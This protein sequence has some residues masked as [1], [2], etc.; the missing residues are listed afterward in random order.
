MEDY[1]YRLANR[2]EELEKLQQQ[3]QIVLQASGVRLNTISS[4]NVALGEWVENIIQ[5][6]YA[7]GAS[8]QIAVNCQVRPGEVA[9]RISDDGRP[10]NPTEYPVLDPA[11]SAQQATQTGRGIHLIRHL[12]DQ[13][14]Y[15]RQ[16]GNNVL[17]LTKHH[18]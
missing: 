4:L 12:V 10:F 1:D 18:P 13:M 9:L 3:L 14:E 15:Q 2:P 11:A 5:Y 16:G 8:H 17:L 6:A 7:D